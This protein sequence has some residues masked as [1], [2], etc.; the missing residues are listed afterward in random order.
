[1]FDEAC[2]SFGCVR[3]R[4]KLLIRRLR[5]VR[6]V[7]CVLERHY[8]RRRLL[9]ARFPE[10]DVVVRRRVERRVQV[11]EVNRLVRYLFAQHA[12][13]VAVVELI[14]PVHTIVCRG[15]LRLRT[16]FL[17]DGRGRG[18]APPLQSWFLTSSTGLC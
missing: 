6:P 5:F 13:V 4:D 10:Q 18:Q 16:L 12:Q 1:R 15:R 9:A 14:C 8:L 11:D 2:E 7:P 17:H 3:V